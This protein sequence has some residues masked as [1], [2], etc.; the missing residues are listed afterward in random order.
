MIDSIKKLGYKD[1]QY[2][3]FLVTQKENL[4]YVIAVGN[5]IISGI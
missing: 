4:D 2:C 3:T 5:G 1:H